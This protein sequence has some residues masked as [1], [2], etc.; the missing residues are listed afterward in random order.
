M[1]VAFLTQRELSV[2]R[3]G[4]GYLSMVSYQLASWSHE[5]WGYFSQN[6]TSPKCG[7][8]ILAAHEV[9]LG[10]ASFWSATTGGCGM[11]GVSPSWG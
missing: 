9:P 8:R 10:L 7:L 3:T 5:G 6:A 1:L 4:L 2:V 11:H